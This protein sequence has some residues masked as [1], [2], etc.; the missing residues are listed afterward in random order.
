MMTREQKRL[1]DSVALAPTSKEDWRDLYETIAAY[2]RRCLARAIVAHPRHA[3]LVEMIRTFAE[4]D[5]ELTHQPVDVRGSNAD[6][7]TTG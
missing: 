7:T 2:E 1:W 4:G 3:E 5:N 6:G